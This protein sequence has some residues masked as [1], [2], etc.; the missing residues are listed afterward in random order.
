MTLYLFTRTVWILT[1]PIAL[2]HYS[3]SL[4]KASDLLPFTS[5]ALHGISSYVDLGG[6]YPGLVSHPAPSVPSLLCRPL[7]T[8]LQSRSCDHP[9]SSVSSPLTLMD[10]SHNKQSGHTCTSG[11]LYNKKK[12]NITR[13]PLCRATRWCLSWYA[14]FV[15]ATATIMNKR[16]QWSTTF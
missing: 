13:T 10:V 5:P 12:K 7:Q 8:P 11:P 15:C 2:R 1:Q 9:V 4:R 14:I 16:P 3:R 6:V